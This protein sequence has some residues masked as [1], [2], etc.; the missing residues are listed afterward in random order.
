MPTVAG[1]HVVRRAS[2]FVAAPGQMIE[3]TLAVENRGDQAVEVT[4]H[5][6][7]PAGWVIHGTPELASVSL[8][9]GTAG[10]AQA[11]Y[12]LK[13]PDQHGPALITGKVAVVTAHGE[14]AGL[15]LDTPI[16]CY[17]PHAITAPDQLAEVRDRLVAVTNFHA[18]NGH[19]LLIDPSRYFPEHLHVKMPQAVARLVAQ[20]FRFA[21]VPVPVGKDL[22]DAVR[23]GD[24]RG[25]LGVARVLLEEDH[26]D[27]CDE[28]YEP[29][30]AAAYPR[31]VRS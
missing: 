21:E 27:P 11:S 13:A 15:L 12:Q 8:A 20:E 22:L 3:L 31:E 14:T 9:P 2:R 18:R 4:I 25:V 1:V 24:N 19:V 26:P 30:H 16:A 7:A 28:V 17:P 10:T 23:V 29:R 5:D 6:A